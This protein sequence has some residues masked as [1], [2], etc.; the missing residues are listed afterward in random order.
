MSSASQ[1]RRRFRPRKP[2]AQRHVGS[3]AVSDLV[4]AIRCNDFAAFSSLLAAPDMNVN[5]HTSEGDVPLVEA[6]R[7]ARLDMATLLL[8]DHGRSDRQTR[9]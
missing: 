5:C 1:G 8:V 4:S 7:F 3:S 9:D 6:C 2:K